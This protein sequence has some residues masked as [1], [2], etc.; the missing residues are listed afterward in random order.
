MLKNEIIR[1]L[2]YGD[3]MPDGQTLNLIDKL[4]NLAQKTISPKGVHGIF[5]IEKLSFLEGNDI[6][7]HLFN[8]QR[9]IIL[10]VTLGAQAEFQLNLFQKTDMQKAVI[11]DAVCDALVEDFADRYCDKIKK[12]L[13]KHELFTNTRFSPGYGDF[14]IEKQKEIV[15]IISTQKNIGLSVTDSF[16][17]LPRKS[18]TAIIGVF[19]FPPKGIQRGCDSCNI[20]NKCKMRGTDR[21]SKQTDF[22]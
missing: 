20:K 11:F 18:I 22:M 19:N 17:L 14:P 15:E 4:I 8:A 10:A 21:C 13:L 9:G 16:T 3:N 6:K 5:D 12:D 7:N 1:Y 2:G